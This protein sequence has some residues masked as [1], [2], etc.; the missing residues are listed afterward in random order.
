[1]AEGDAVKVCLRIRPIIQREQGDKVPLQWKV[2]NSTVSQVDG[3][4]SFT[5]DRVFDSHETTAQVYQEVAV[6]IIR[7]AL[8]G[9][10]GTIFAYGQ[11]SSG[12]T[13]TMMGTPDNLGIIPR[14]VQ[15]V[16]HII[17]EAPDREFLLRV[18]YM[19]IYNETVTDLLCDDG[20]KKPLEI[21]EDFNRNVYVASLTEE[22]VMTPEH[23]MKWIKKGEKNRHYGET[24]MNDHSSRSHTIFRMIVESR[25][26][27]E[28]GNSENCEGAVMVSH[29]NLVDLAGSERASQT[30]AEGVRFK[31]GCNIN[32][33][34]FILGQVI[35][36]LSDG[37]AGGFI[38]YR[39]SKL[40]RILQN[41]LGGNT[42]TVIICT[43]T[44]VSFDET[45]STLQFASTAKHV[46]NTPHVN[47]VLDD[48]ALL[49][50]YRKEIMELK[51]QL[52]DLEESSEMKAHAMA[53]EER[54]QLL[55]EIKQLQ[56]EREDRI[57]NLTNI[58]VASSQVSH[59]D[60][61]PRKRRVTWAPGKIQKSLCVAGVSSFEI[62]SKIS[63][64]LAKRPKIST[65]S[66]LQ[67]FDESNRTEN[68]F[69]DSTRLFDDTALD[70]DC[71]FGNKVT[72]RDKAAWRSMID[73]N[74]DAPI[75]NSA[76]I[77]DSSI[78]ELRS[79]EQKVSDLENKL[80][81]MTKEYE[82]EVR[83]RELLEGETA[84]L[85]R[86]VQCQ[87]DNVGLVKRLELQL[88]PLKDELQNR[89]ERNEQ[90]HE[91][92]SLGTPEEQKHLEINDDQVE[93]IATND[94]AYSTHVYNDWDNAIEEPH[95]N[96]SHDICREQIQMLEQKI[97][98][99]EGNAQQNDFMESLQI[100][101]DLMK[102]KETA[103]EELSLLR[104]NF[105][106]VVLENESL[107]MD[108][109]S[110][111]K[112][113]A[114]KKETNEFELLEKETQKEYETQLIHEIANLKALVE[115]SEVSNQ[116]LLAE[117]DSKS[118]LLKD[119]EKVIADL[120]KVAEDLQKKMS[121]L[122]LSASLGE[123]DKLCEE[124]F[125]LRHSLSDAETVTRDAQREAAFLR[126]ENME[127]KE[128]MEELSVRCNQREKDASMCEKQ[129]EMEK[130]SYRRMQAD[131]QKELQCSFSEINKLSG[132]LA[133]RV[134]KDLLS[135]VELE[136]EVADYAKRLNNSL[137]DK[138]ILEKEVACL[139]SYKSLPGEVEN[140]QDQVKRSS[141]ELLSLTNEKKQSDCIINN[142]KDKLQEQTEH[143]EKLTEEVTLVQA[144]CHQTE[145]KYTELKL[146]H[147]ALQ[148]Q[149]SL[150]AEEMMLK[151]REAESL[152]KEMDELKHLLSAT[153]QEKEELVLAKQELAVSIKEVEE[154]QKST[155]SER[156]DLQDQLSNLSS[157]V[158]TLQQQAGEQCDLNKMK[159][160]LE[161][162]NCALIT[163]KEQLHE[164]LDRMKSS[165]D[166]L[167]I[168]NA[169]ASSKLENLQD[170]MKRIVQHRD[171]LYDKVEAIKAEKDSLKQDLRENIE[172]SI[173]TQD[174][175]R[176]TQ[177][178]LK[179][180]K[181]L[182]AEL[183][184]QIAD[185]AGG[186]SLEA[187]IQEQTVQRERSILILQLEEN[188]AKFEMITNEK[189]E[190]EGNNQS[191]IS[192]K[193]VLQQ[194]LQCAELALAKVEGENNELEQKLCCLVEKLTCVS[195]ELDELRNNLQEEKD[196]KDEMD[197]NAEEL[198]QAG[199]TLQEQLKGK[200]KKSDNL[201]ETLRNVK[202]E[203]D[204][205]RLDLQE[206]IEM[207]IDTQEE[208]RKALD[209]LK[210]KTQL[211]D[212]MSSQL[213]GK[214]LEQKSIE[215]QD[216][217]R[218]TQEKLKQ[219]K[220]LVAEL[221]KQIADC[222]GGI[223][224]EAE[225][226]EQTVQRERSIL[227]LQLEENKAKFEMIT[228][229]KMELEGNN[230]SLISE[231]EV[232]QQRLQCA[233][234]ALAKVEGENNELEQKLCCLVEKLTCVSG[235]L[236]ELRNNLQ[237]EKDLK[238]E[239]DRNAEEPCQAGV[240]LQEQLKGKIKKSNNLHETL[241]N[242][243]SE[244][245]QLRLDL[246]EN[247]E[248]SI[249]TQE[250]LRKALDELK[251]KTQ[252]LDEMSSQLRGK[253]LEQKSI[254]TQDEL[255]ITQ[256]ELKQQKLLVAELRKQIAD[257]AG[258][259]SLQ[260]EIQEQTVQRERSI[261]ILQLEENKAKFEMI[262]NEKMEL[263]GN[264]Q[265]LISEKEVLQQRLQCAELALAKVEGENNELEQKLCCLVEK[266]TCVSGELDELRNNLQ[267]EKDLKD[268]MDRNAEEPCQSIDTQEELRKALDELKN[269][270]QLLDEMSS[271]VRG[272]DL[273][274]KVLAL[275]EEL[276][277]KTTEHQQLLQRAEELEQINNCL[278]SE[279]E[280]LKDMVKM[281][282]TL[283]SLQNAKLE[284]EKQ[285]LD[286]Q[287]KLEVVVQEKNDLNSVQDKLLAEL[288]ALKEDLT[289]NKEL[290]ASL[291]E[292]LLQK[293]T[294]QQELITK[295]EELEQVQSNLRCEVESLTKNMIEA[296]SPV[297]LLQ[298]ERLESKQLVLQQNIEVLA[299]ENEVQTTEE[300]VTAELSDKENNEM[301]ETTED[302]Q[303][304]LQNE[305]LAQTQTLES[306]L[307][308]PLNSL[309]KTEL[310]TLRNEQMKTEEE[311]VGLQQL[312]AS[313]TQEREELQA[314]LQSVLSERDQLKEDLRENVE[315]SI[316]IQEDLRMAQDELQLQRQ[317]VEQ[318][319]G[320]ISSLDK[321][322][323]TLE[324]E[325]CDTTTMF[326]EA[327]S[328]KEILNQS[329]QKFA[330]ELDQLLNDLKC[331]ENA[332]EEAECEKSEVFKKMCELTA[333]L[334]AVADERDKMLS[335]MES[336]QKESIE[337]HGELRR[338]KEQLQEQEQIIEKLTN[339][340]S[341]LEEKSSSL[342][343][344]LHEKI[345]LLTEAVGVQEVLVQSKQKMA[346]E[347][348]NLMEVVQHKDLE[349][350]QV[351]VGKEEA[352]Q[353]I[354]ALATE[355]S[356][357][358]QEKDEL[359]LSTENLQTEA[360][361]L[362][363]EIQ[364]LQH[365]RDLFAEQQSQ[366]TSQLDDL[367][368]EIKQLQQKMNL[369]NA[370]TQ[371]LENDKEA[372]QKQVKQYELEIGSLLQEQEQRIE[373]LTNEFSLLEEKSSSLE[374]ELQEKITLLT[375]AVGEREVLVQ[376]KQNM[377]VE[378]E[379]LMEAVKSKDSEVKQVAVEKEEASHKILELSKELRSISQE[380]D[381][382]QLSKDTLQEEA[383][384]LREEIQQL[385]HNLLAE[386]QN[387]KNSKLDGLVAVI[388]QL[389]EKMK[390]SDAS[391]LQLETD[392][393]SLQKQVH[394]YEL[395]MASVRQEQEQ[396]QQL[397]ERVRSEKENIYADLQAQEKDTA[398]LRDTLNTTQTRLQAIVK[399][400]DESNERLL[401]KVGE[402]NE[403]LQ[404]ISSLQQELQQLQQEMKD[405]KRENR[406]LSERVDL[407]EKEITALRSIQSEPVEEED[408]L[409]ERTEIFKNKNQEFTR[410]MENISSVCLHHQS[411]LNN[412]SS[413]LQSEI[414][415]QKESMSAIKE[416]LS[417]AFSREFGNLQT[418]NYK[419]N[420]Q[421][422]TLLNK[423]KVLYNN[424]AIKEEHYSLIN[425]YEHD[426][427][428]VQKRNDEL[429]ES[430]EQHGT[431]RSEAVSEDLK[432]CELEFLTRLLFKK[433][434]VL[435]RVEDGFSKVQ[436]Q[437]NNTENDLRE[438]ANCKKRFL[439]WL[440]ELRGVQYEAKTLIE[441]VQQENSR[442]TGVVQRLA[443]HLKTVAQSRMK[444]DTIAYLNKLGTEL[445]EKK[446][447]NKELLQRMQHLAP[448]GDSSILQEEN[449]RLHDHLKTLQVDLKRL[450]CKIKDLENE[451][452]SAKADARRKEENSSRLEEKL[453]S[454]TAESELLEIH[455]KMTEKEKHLQNALKE[456]QVL[457]EKV[458]KGSAPYKDEMD[459][460]HSQLVK[461]EMNRI[462]L[463]KAADQ[464]IASLKACLED[465]EES[466][467]K[468][469]EQLRRAQK[470]A[471][472]T[473]CGD[474][475]GTGSSQF[476]PTCGG[477]SGIVQ[478]TA[479]L[480]LQSENAALKREISQYK[481]KCHQ[482]SRNLTFHE[483]EIK[484][485][486]EKTETNPSTPISVHP[487]QSN[488]EEY[489]Q[490]TV[491]P[492]RSGIPPPRITSPRKTEMH[493]KNVR[494]P[495][496][497]LV[498]E[499]RT[500]SP[501][502]TER[503]SVPIMSPGKT[504]P[505]R[506]LAAS[507][508]K[509]DV[510]LFS[511]LT[512]SPRKNLHLQEVHSSKDKF[513]DMRSKSKPYYPTKFFD[514][515]MLG[516]LPD[517]DMYAKAASE[518][519]EINWWD[520]AEKKEDA[521]EC[522]TS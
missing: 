162:K 83:K 66:I 467:R 497:T 131:L 80:K 417:S 309:D 280:S 491:S 142:Q 43:I 95:L 413:E 461:V 248:M 178:E 266:L 364:Q 445:Q 310:V 218:I 410:L 134:P 357:V 177:E 472:S 255:R 105:D 389:Q 361:K 258:G 122:E 409:A 438:E 462:K 344:E 279:G 457:Q 483:D 165:H 430:L 403:L 140:L 19:E 54:S 267:E 398:Q 477:G 143:I 346:A 465:K 285:F 117:L 263:E 296:R 195:G 74:S 2:E 427:C 256:E 96:N 490:A 129:L 378:I 56:K 126:S 473:F 198:C 65:C 259:I 246:Q 395:D 201:H 362:R 265:S 261:L 35:K 458:A 175:L 428:A 487:S 512:E 157:L 158:A 229:E 53:K 244:R 264:N 189:M 168:N 480:I 173:E 200:I 294:E 506:R 513:F 333:E 287:Q 326:K 176:I 94:S 184:K 136:K 411:F 384:K 109:D 372:L 93:D 224:L 500:V 455:L 114:E 88:I 121:Y 422:Q 504:G 424:T 486:K 327:T 305:E 330:S 197:R 51:K 205:L 170:E 381:D 313:V 242:V 481:K 58:V 206:N 62:E 469:K 308:L 31:E 441:G 367:V 342:E 453:R 414:E 245:D 223:S 452:S 181:L 488:A 204:Q 336:F 429:T 75:Q 8:Q 207:S 339:E 328:E 118:K 373:K 32:R 382:L 6:P 151:D 214:D 443:K 169:E 449:A 416:S 89:P 153:L 437:V 275:Y 456:I 254:E 70:I 9:Y 368:T 385:Q 110:L 232:L 213:R 380:R 508:N 423:F 297:Q 59:E 386:H 148:E 520:R 444:P 515:S 139:S 268:E 23:V 247:I 292:Q 498:H 474:E 156:D 401:E 284:A 100:C 90:S 257:C 135:R 404:Q 25:E 5:F 21:R 293:T 300:K 39:D 518:T 119:Q 510:P 324:S 57:W 320:V 226:Q 106:S 517:V 460:L 37:Q 166:I 260:A 505:Y 470:D 149:C 27:N 369:S 203:R 332:L 55:A 272:K 28:P 271:Q 108:L 501:N 415:V 311:I 4:K 212:E 159:L 115:N 345:N 38:N 468:L 335:S 390:L 128:Q 191:L 240:T 289:Q 475:E 103:L 163:E 210:N 137:E 186:I 446:E 450:Q 377:A 22:L 112:Y 174:E 188:K 402:V 295:K 431:K 485:I 421:L 221:R 341:L 49:K 86:Q 322:C 46:R 466:L 199:V 522:K 496:K 102:E 249:D 276:Q 343:R 84:A 484:K 291:Q 208:L 383:D 340:I 516:T 391:V 317:K 274:Q 97:V 351:A 171:E 85:K 463:S 418:E 337:A 111:E 408:E 29:L 50:R 511:A 76:E 282:T 314:R 375:E 20:K 87:D 407:M 253:D 355:L 356:S 7:S 495:C 503:H 440:D 250:E 202:S 130:S 349:L 71:N 359:Q 392:K 350:A 185:C 370:T 492:I 220:L 113:I 155:L 16:F 316:E 521:N 233:E 273:E 230:Q 182:V 360:G 92:D 152:L 42:K 241:R 72:Q 290:I 18:S 26:Q 262:T 454:S 288:G 187:E 479:M 34:L 192:E 24:K 435:K 325:L 154:A 146:L 235:E 14:A 396:F 447:K 315:M 286:L 278:R 132:L 215:T 12:K 464:Q 3:T 302:Q 231:K 227:I 216:E 394:Q 190:L 318:L 127:L 329:K 78:Q 209:E 120:K 79:M 400:R 269:K 387:Q 419:L 388:K 239:M 299:Q 41:S 494:S 493:R 412:I 45:L 238:D 13:Y 432:F 219:Q 366:N 73:F 482:L 334:K 306:E 352:S 348:E 476:P 425:D 270:T 234:L 338:N 307:D 196:L 124:V 160:E 98:D 1:M 228:N 69:E 243:K 459:S 36:K 30:G 451:L 312:I 323:S 303:R 420:V 167:Q 509:T 123:G 514:N 141:E 448:S 52:E 478:S 61:V 101:E 354:L 60:R 147:D 471:D 10:N 225:I 236:D 374:R 507:P 48:Q 321:K 439:L 433:V 63:S 138:Q 502:K 304:P 434:D 397:L 47:E 15:E 319:E 44:S 277:Q 179:Q 499:P 194:R 164:Q 251:N 33:S 183:R 150:T 442:V 40:T 406:D 144:K 125:Q 283:E 371:Q 281:Q 217:L 379:Q 252:L 133:G 82:E 67:E 405:E 358:S 77:Q 193:E 81:T 298:N 222:A 365:T 376:S 353:K 347:I 17:Q 145:Q 161:E 426:L 393:A 489:S 91:T 107:K 172:L 301:K 64:G 104:I 519:D 11:T 331:K 68:D 211:F 116:E 436:L 180:Q 237:E 399:E 99:L 363:G